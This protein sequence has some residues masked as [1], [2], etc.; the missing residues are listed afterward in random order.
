[1]ETVS[2]YVLIES[3]VLPKGR[4]NRNVGVTTDLDEAK[5]HKARNPVPGTG[6]SYI[7]FDYQEFTTATD[8]FVAGAESALFMKEMEQFKET[9][10]GVRDRLVDTMMGR[11]PHAR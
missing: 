11:Q 8:L 10:Q 3:T 7:E 5:D 1:M 9:V 4:I 2:V 6:T